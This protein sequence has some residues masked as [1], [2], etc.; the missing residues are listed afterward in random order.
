MFLN[1]GFLLVGSALVLP[2][3]MM[4]RKMGSKLAMITGT[5]ASSSLLCAG[6]LGIFGNKYVSIGYTIYLGLFGTVA[7][8][9]TFCIVKSF[10]V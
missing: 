2:N 8:I 3:I 9:A 6:F 4:A 1:L 10:F 7:Q 5:V